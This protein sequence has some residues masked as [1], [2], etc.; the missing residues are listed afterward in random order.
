MKSFTLIETLI[1]TILVFILT[2]SIYNF[3]SESRFLINRIK[4]YKDFEYKSSIV[5]LT[6]KQ[7]NL[8]EVLAD[9]NIT[10]DSIIHS[11]KK[12]KIFLEIS[13]DSNYEKINLQKIK[14]YDKYYSTYVYSIGE[15]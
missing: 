14:A 10:N 4:D 9:M 7:G 3:T 13:N 5:L 1:A 15:K 8:Y 12:Y 6:K 11:L 2:I